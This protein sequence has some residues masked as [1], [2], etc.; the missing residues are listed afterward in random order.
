[1]KIAYVGRFSPALLEKSFS[2]EEE[3][4][5][6]QWGFPLGT[7]VIT[8]FVEKGH[9]VSVITEDGGA[10]E[11]REYK[12]GAGVS[13][14]LVPT[15]RRTIISGLT[16]YSME[17]RLM[18]ECIRSASPDVVFAQWTYQNA[19]AGILSDYPTLVVAHDS[20]WRIF[21]MARDAMSFLRALYAHFV[22]IPRIGNLVAVS[23]H[24]A[25]DFRKLHDYSGL[26]D[27]IPNGIDV[28]RVR[29]P[30]DKEI[31]ERADTIVCV[32]QWGRLK[33]VQ[34]LLK[35]FALLRARH[36]NW[37][38]IVYGNGLD[39]NCAGQWMAQHDIACTNVDLRGYASQ[40]EIRCV[41]KNNADVFCSPTLEESFGMVFLEAMAQGVPCV[42]GEKSGAVPW[43]I[44]DGGALCD[45]GD[46]NALADCLERVMLDSNLRRRMGECAKKR[47]IEKFNLGKVVDAYL[48]RLSCTVK[49]GL[50]AS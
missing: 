29:L 12:S 31:R 10:N 49:G 13:V 21:R 33:N 7:D 30:G 23:E 48:S 40:E 14:F 37:R 19:Q 5:K 1:M 26:L 20:P 39:K 42:G 28:E 27:V 3:L 43:V 4:P 6:V 50:R 38:L 36:G 45:V 15:R 24:L 41:L 32:S 34:T 46:P 9:E 22:V 2:F 18:A 44:G 17:T 47:V 35:A 11:V 8:K 25:D 16:F